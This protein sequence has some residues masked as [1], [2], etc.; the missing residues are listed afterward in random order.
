[1]DSDNCRFI[2]GR[3]KKMFKRNSHLLLIKMFYRLIVCKWELSNE[4]EEV[5]SIIY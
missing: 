1:M 3:E 2:L 5:P 4:S